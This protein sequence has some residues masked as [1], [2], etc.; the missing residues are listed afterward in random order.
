VLFKQLQPAYGEQERYIS[1]TRASRETMEK[2][3]RAEMA[4]IAAE[5]DGAEAARARESLARVEADREGV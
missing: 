4:R 3:L 2:L 1:A 5:E